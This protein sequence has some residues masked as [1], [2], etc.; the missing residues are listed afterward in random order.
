LNIVATKAERK[1]RALGVV[2]TGIGKT[3]FRIGYKCPDPYLARITLDGLRHHEQLNG[4]GGSIVEI[5]L[6]GIKPE[7]Q[8]PIFIE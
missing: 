7:A 3:M 6:L 1:N 4:F 5:Y 8:T 2:V